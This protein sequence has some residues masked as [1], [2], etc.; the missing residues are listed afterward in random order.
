MSGDGFATV[1]P[2]TAGQFPA[3]SPNNTFVMQDQTPYQFDDRFIE[4]SFTIP[5]TT[6]AAGTRGFGAIF[7]DAENAGSSKIEYFGR[8]ASRTRGQPRHLCGSHGRERAAGVPRRAV[9]QS[10]GN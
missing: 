4:Q 8:D 9:R 7:V 6:T 2:A 3:F 1:N 10:G 5:G